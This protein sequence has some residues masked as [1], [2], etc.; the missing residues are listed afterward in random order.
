M[1]ERFRR[2]RAEFGTKVVVRLSVLL[3]GLLG[4]VVFG[5]V[6]LASAW[7]ALLAGGGLLLGFLLRE[8]IAWGV[9]YY[10]RAVS[11]GLFVYGIVL[12]LGDRLGLGPEGKLLIITATTV[13]IFDLQFWSLSHPEV[14]NPEQRQETVC[15]KQSD[16]P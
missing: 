1:F 2:I 15:G 7:P 11:V 6:A 12:F 16:A 9:A 14:Y 10:T 8:P 13:L 3:V 5:L 4:M